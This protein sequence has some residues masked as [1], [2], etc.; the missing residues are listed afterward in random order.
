M[1]NM[2]QNLADS[3]LSTNNRRIQHWSYQLHNHLDYQCWYI[4][5]LKKHTSRNRNVSV[6]ISMFPYSSEWLNHAWVSDWYKKRNKGFYLQNYI[7]LVKDANSDGQWSVSSIFERYLDIDLVLLQVHTASGNL[8]TDWHSNWVS[9]PWICCFH[10]YNRYMYMKSH[11]WNLGMN[12]YQGLNWLVAV[13]QACVSDIEL[14]CYVY[15]YFKL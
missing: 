2:A 5:F 3:G 6:R 10:C 1:K 4:H 8:V 7:Y 13:F 11:M 9:A 14:F 15:I 12:S